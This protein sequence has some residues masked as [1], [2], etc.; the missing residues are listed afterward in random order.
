MSHRPDEY[1]VYMLF[2]IGNNGDP[3]QTPINI[4]FVP[5]MEYTLSILTLNDLWRRKDCTIPMK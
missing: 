4:D 3:C 5:I 1:E 2:I